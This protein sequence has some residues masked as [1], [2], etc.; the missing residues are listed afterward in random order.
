M[1]ENKRFHLLSMYACVWIYDD[2]LLVRFRV[3][4]YLVSKEIYMITNDTSP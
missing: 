1:Y 2:A 3:V 4:V